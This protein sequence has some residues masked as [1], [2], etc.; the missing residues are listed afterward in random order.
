MQINLFPTAQAQQKH[1]TIYRS[2]AGSGKTYTLTREYLTLALQSPQYFRTILAVTF[3]NKATQEMKT[4]IIET[5]HQLANG[6]RGGIQKELK[7]ATGLEDPLLQKRA[8]DVLSAIL[9]DYSYFAVSTIDSFFQTVIR[10]FAKEVGLQAGF[11]VELEQDKVLEELIDLL[12]KDVGND[13]Y[14]REWLTQYAA[15]RV[16]EGY[17]W[18]IRQDIKNLAGEI[19]K[20]DFKKHEKKLQHIAAD[21]QHF[22]HF[23]HMLKELR[24]GFEN[25]MQKT[26]GEA[27]QLMERFGLEVAD[28]SYGTSGVAGYFLNLLPEKG[29]YEPGSR[30]LAA[31]D[32]PDKW[33]SKS[34]KKKDAIEAAVSA[35]LNDLLGQATGYYQEEH[36]KYVTAQQILRFVYSFGI[37]AKLTDKLRHYREEHDLMLIS[38]A[39]VFLRDIIGE[40]D[41]PFIYEKTG[42]HYQ[43]FLIDEFQDTSGFQWENFKPLVA[44]SVAAGNYNLVVG[45]TKQSIYR[46]RGGDWQ[47]LLNQIEMDIGAHQTN[48]VE[49]SNN[50][51]SCREIIAFNNQL[52]FES[53]AALKQL[54]LEQIAGIDDDAERG[55]LEFEAQNIADAYKDVFQHFPAVK[56]PTARC[57]FINLQFLENKQE[58]EETEEESGDWKAQARQNMIRT[59]EQLQD[60]G[61]R[62]KD[63]ALLVRTKGDGKELADVLLET[64]ENKAAGSPYCYQVV[65]NE[66]LFLDSAASVCLLLNILRYMNN[67]NDLV[68]RANMVYD[69][70]M[71]I[72][73]NTDRDLHTLFR[74]ASE[75]EKTYEQYLPDSF[76]EKRPYLNKLPLYELVET[77][78]LEFDLHKIKSEWAYL[79]AFQDAVLNFTQTERGDIVTFLEWWETTGHKTSVQLSQSLDAIR[80]YTIHTSKGLQFKAVIIPYCN[81]KL[82]HNTQF[83]NFIW[84]EK[85]E[86]PFNKLEVLPIKYTGKLRE[87]IFRQDYY[88]EQMKAY[89]DNLNLLYVAFTRAEE[90]LFACAPLPAFDKKT[91]LAKATEINGLL[92]RLLEGQASP[93]ATGSAAKEAQTDLSAHWNPDSHCFTM[94]ELEQAQHKEEKSDIQQLELRHYYTQ[95]WRKRLAVRKR[96]GSLSYAKT[97]TEAAGIN[98]NHTIHAILAK[99]K[100]PEDLTPVLQEVYFDGLISQE[101]QPVIREKIE[102]LFRHPVAGEWFSK[103]WKVRTELPILAAGGFITQPDRVITN[104]QLAI[105]IDFKT[106]AP[107]EDRDDSKSIHIYKSLLKRMNY[108][109]IKGYLFYLDEEKA[110][111]I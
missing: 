106:E 83:N 54:Y 67:S 97:D 93:E 61:Y 102:S 51:R 13:R 107:E 94:G 59:V 48:T 87:T 66:S 89:L 65:S 27:L 3:T 5:L 70:Q 2:S 23:L 32:N 19:F 100:T 6:L 101:E 40:N 21:P 79:Q 92:Y 78:I 15:D 95:R 36:Q 99:I 103:D 109:Q 62:L 111:E 90:S 72:L 4:R 105:V 73:K 37:L 82:D 60:K 33:Y 81:W 108:Q 12:L 50:W 8:G 91:G 20:E 17:T 28:F 98:W 52:F 57:G 34:S 56:A 64:E 39:S 75:K 49:L 41:A 110:V 29:K 31:L 58:E 7:E 71:Y 86:K 69:Y 84:S 74:S 24:L 1:F 76:I 44:N 80:I 11:K 45:D 35:G 9:H 38:D 25:R 88:R 96:S 46:W 63:I 55:T 14:L 43:H 77:L 68:A 30:A 26:A 53:A 16:D 42:S 104:K 85:E 22:L 47:L 18:D 10:S